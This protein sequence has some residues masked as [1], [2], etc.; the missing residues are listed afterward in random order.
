MFGSGKPRKTAASGLLAQE[1][2]SA[3]AP[4][5]GAAPAEPAP[6]S[7]AAAPHSAPLQD[8]GRG[9]YGTPQPPSAAEDSPP[10]PG[11]HSSAAWGIPGGKFFK[12]TRDFF[13]S[14]H[15]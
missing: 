15:A 10:P 8:V 14:M 7:A 12:A 5:G 4:G 9:P 1:Q 11:P 6:A 2:P 3:S 13:K